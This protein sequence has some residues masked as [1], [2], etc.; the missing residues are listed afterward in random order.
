MANTKTDASRWSKLALYGIPA[1]ALYAGLYRFETLM[2]DISRQGHWHAFVPIAFAFAVSYFHG[3]F[4]AS[5]WDALG[6][7]AKN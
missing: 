6:I 7:K 2:I 1:V 3:G 5:F 4:T